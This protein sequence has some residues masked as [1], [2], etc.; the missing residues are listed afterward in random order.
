M[1]EGKLL[2]H[3]RIIEELG[4]GGMGIVYRAEDTKLDR[5]VAIKV[6]P[7]AALSNEDDKARFY[8]EAKAAA[9]LQ[10]PNIA[11]VFQVDEAV[12]Q[13]ASSEELRPF[14][15]MEFVEGETLEAK[16]KKGPLNLEEAVRLAKQIASGLQAAHEKEIVHRDIK[17]GNVMLTEKGEVKILDFG[18]AQTNASTKLTRMGSTM[19]TIGYMSPEQARGEEV[20][21]RTDLWA[22]GVIL[23]EM[24]SGRD[25]FPGDYEQAVIYEILNQD[26][27]PLTSLRTGVPM[28]LERIAF[29][30]LDK[31]KGLRYQNAVGLTADLDA[32]LTRDL[33]STSHVSTLRTVRSSK[34]RSF[35]RDSRPL[36]R[37]RTTPL[38]LLIAIVSLTYG[39]LSG[40]ESA[41]RPALKIPLT[42][43]N[44]L[45]MFELRMSNDGR[46]IFYANTDSTGETEL[47]RWD[48]LSGIKESLDVEGDPGHF[49]LSND[50]SQVAYR[51]GPGEL[52][53]ISELPSGQPRRIG[54]KLVGGAYA[55]LTT[56]GSIIAQSIDRRQLL[57]TIIE[58]GDERTL[59]VLDTL[60][61][62]TA[63][64]GGPTPAYDSERDGFYYSLEFPLGDQAP[65]L[66]FYSM[67]RGEETHLV[68]GGL[69]ARVLGK[70]HLL[71]QEREGQKVF[72][73]E[74]DEDKPEWRGERELIMDRG[75]IDQIATTSKGDLLFRE[76]PPFRY[77]LQAW[78]NEGHLQKTDAIS[79][80]T[81]GLFG[82]TPL[83]YQ[84][85]TLEAPSFR[86]VE[87]TSVVSYALNYLPDEPEIIHLR[88]QL[89]SLDGGPECASW[90]PQQEYVY[91]TFGSGNSFSTYRVPTDGSKLQ[92]HW[93]DVYCPTFSRDGNRVALTRKI[94]SGFE[95]VVME[96]DSG[97]E[98]ILDR[99]TSTTNPGLSISFSPDGSVLRYIDDGFRNILQHVE[100]SSRIDLS[101]ST[102]FSWDPSSSYIYYVVEGAIVRRRVSHQ[103]GELEVRR[104]EEVIAHSL[105]DDPGT[106]LVSI[107]E[108]GFI[109]GQQVQEKSQTINWW[110]N[111]ESTL[112]N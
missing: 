54:D 53:L 75:A 34:N 104:P 107:S 58:S 43:D 41:D 82:A 108:D 73:R 47:I 77:Q 90:G 70:H 18:L 52:Y 16:I 76:V 3:Y 78:S 7:A 40:D 61:Y 17:S 32:L 98:W 19:G 28:E 106:V 46:Y 55:V 50:G 95:L 99:S 87:G 49:S 36:W 62:P 30:L 56:H 12:P 85:A 44:S 11:V 45:Y 14:I 51:T 4:R 111:Y 31:D 105:L 24:I 92:E 38:L 48:L 112:E 68:D 1:V 74:M 26:P 23:F 13:G 6:L 37:Q 42:T 103:N 39:V 35:T 89:A 72:V 21:A 27:E 57:E 100:S 91:Y 66:Y 15:A 102:S 9:Q 29:K 22:L 25:P 65:Q 86:Q 97:R 60:Q 64:F 81:T 88:S 93:D 110:M 33:S 80:F 109:T 67:N 79:M 83:G 5:T 84:L 63:Q 10:H 59:L 20:D 96:L 2:A 69:N 94:E 101:I 71:F 8:R